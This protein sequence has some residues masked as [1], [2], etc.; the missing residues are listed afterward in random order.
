MSKTKSNNLK[1]LKLFSIVFLI[2]TLSIGFLM[3]TPR[4][5]SLAESK[6]SSF[7]TQEVSSPQALGVKEEPKVVIKSSEISPPNF[8]AHSALA[9]DLETGQLLYEK[10][11]HQR[12]F[13]ASTTKIMTALVALEH[14]KSA[15]VLT[16]TPEA[17]VGGSSMGLL[18]GEQLTF[19]S[20]LYG[21]LLNSGNDAAFAIA[22][23]YPGG[24]S[25]FVEK[26]NEKAVSLGLKD[27]HFQN[28]A[29]FDGAEHYSSAYDLSQ[30]AK[31][32]VANNQL[33]KVVSTKETTI[34]SLDKSK[35]HNLKNLNKLLGVDGVIGIKTG[36]T[37]EA[38]ENLVGLVE[39]NGRK[40]LTVVLSSSD[41]F[42]ETKS[43]ID[44]LYSNFTWT[45]E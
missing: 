39:R 25:A 23:N 18:L 27:S 20:L 4:A 38:G 14:Y 17:L 42:G 21:M 28:P 41:R 24:V 12:L 44:W 26:M 10:N 37:E 16:I 7:N 31:A 33:A 11:T 5:V 13:P 22:A 36:F 3:I 19:R 40:V 35:S 15:D 32:A 43:L 9:L 1:L 34:L 29:G 8:S 30:I 45:L 2:L 6:I